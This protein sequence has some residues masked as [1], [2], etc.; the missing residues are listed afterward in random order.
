MTQH[1]NT[2][3]LEPVVVTQTD[4]DFLKKVADELDAKG[5]VL[6]QTDEDTAG[7]PVPAAQRLN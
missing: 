6:I 1:V 2:E 7:T 4:A 3:N 5:E